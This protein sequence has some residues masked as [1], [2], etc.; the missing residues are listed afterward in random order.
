V[1]RAVRRRPARSRRRG[2]K[3]RGPDGGIPFLKEGS[4]A[5]AA[6]DDARRS[7]ASRRELARHPD[8][9]RV[10]P[11]VGALDEAAFDD[12]MADD[13]D[14]ALGLLADMTRATDAGL[15]ELARRLAGRLVLD[16]ARRG[17]ARPRGVGRIAVARYQPEAGDLDVDASTE[18]LVEAKAAGAA[19]D[20]ERLRVRRWVQPRTAICLLVDRSGS[21]SGR[22]LATGAV[23]AAAVAFRAP[24]DFSVVSFA[25]DAVVVKGQAAVVPTASVVDGVLALRSHGTTDLAGAL[26]VASQQLRRSAAGRKITVLLSDCRATEPGDVAA[27]ASALD[28]LAILA[29]AGDDEAAVELAGTTGASITTAA[30]PTD[31]ADAL[32]RLLR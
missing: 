27:A 30:G 24:D 26:R 32:A 15:R 12:L 20:P 16:V 25:R 7:T 1:V 9:G 28:E 31:V 6:I 19:V 23:A 8:L 3:S 22:P 11:E 10:S 5:A 18:A 2:G 21:M 13:P 17:P 14:E 4:A 29:P